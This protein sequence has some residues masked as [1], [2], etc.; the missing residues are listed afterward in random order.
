[1]SLI[2]P[3]RSVVS[4]AIRGDGNRGALGGGLVA[5]EKYHKPRLRASTSCRSALNDGT[6]YVFPHSSAG[7]RIKPAVAYP[8]CRPRRND[9]ASSRLGEQNALRSQVS[10]TGTPQRSTPETSDQRPESSSWLEPF[11]T[12]K[13]GKKPW[14]SPPR[15]CDRRD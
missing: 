4:V 8:R 13:S 11:A 3:G 14:R 12:S 2:S 1:M 9:D 5:C 10:L 15:P 6:E 7:C